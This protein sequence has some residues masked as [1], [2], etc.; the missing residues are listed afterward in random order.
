MISYILHCVITT[1][2]CIC[3]SY[4]SLALGHDNG[5][6]VC[7][8]VSEVTLTNW[9]VP[10]NSK[11]NSVCN[12]WDVLYV[13]HLKKNLPH[14]NDVIMSAMA[15]K[16]TSLTIVYATVYSGADQ[17]QSSVSLAFSRGIHRWPVNSLHKRPK[18]LKKFPFDDVIII[19]L[20]GICYHLWWNQWNLVYFSTPL[21]VA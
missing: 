21:F 8:D 6:I 9:P 12:L 5:V 15:S 1:P 3:F 20:V 7:P 10:N 13:K 11:T 4:A 19:F 14:Y 2:R 17:H 16:I 18:M